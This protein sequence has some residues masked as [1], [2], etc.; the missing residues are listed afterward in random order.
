MR[1]VKIAKTRIVKIV[2]NR[3]KYK[4][5]RKINFIKYP[6]LICLTTLICIIPPV[7]AIYFLVTIMLIKENVIRKIN[8]NKNYDPEIVIYKGEKIR[9]KKL[10][11]DYLSQI[12]END[13][14]KIHETQL[15]NKY[16]YLD[17]Y[18]DDPQIKLNITN[19][20]LEKFSEIKKKKVNKI[21]TVF[22]TQS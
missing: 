3:F 20:V 14:V 2:Q 16:F 18:V 11:S 8:T 19:K 10:I 1:K 9:K 5:K 17:E 15:L 6:I 21:D 12:S 13:S 4:K 22:I 7:I